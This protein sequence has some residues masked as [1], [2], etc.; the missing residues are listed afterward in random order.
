MHPYLAKESYTYLVSSLL[1][2]PI[3]FGQEVD[4]EVEEGDGRLIRTTC[5]RY[6]NRQNMVH[7]DT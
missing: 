3:A 7:F 2:H 1:I 4:A 5:I 6:I